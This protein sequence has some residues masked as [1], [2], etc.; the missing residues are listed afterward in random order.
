MTGLLLGRELHVIRQA[1]S[2]SQ[3]EGTKSG[4][5]RLCK[6]KETSGVHPWSSLIRDDHDNHGCY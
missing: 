2:V 3:S 1:L 5:N 6:E 4:N